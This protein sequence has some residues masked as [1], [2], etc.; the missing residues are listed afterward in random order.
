MYSHFFGVEV[1][2]APLVRVIF[3]LVLCDGSRPSDWHIIRMEGSIDNQLTIIN[4][5]G[6]IN[7]WK[8][9]ESSLLSPVYRTN[10]IVNSI[11]ISNKKNETPDTYQAIITTIPV[12]SWNHVKKKEI[13]QMILFLFSC[14]SRDALLGFQIVQLT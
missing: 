1:G 5:T 9:R 8:T 3:T 11:P 10:Y 13:C 7:G 6:I 4:Q 12:N 14:N 2:M